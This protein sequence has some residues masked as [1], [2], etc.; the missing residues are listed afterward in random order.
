MEVKKKTKNNKKAIVLTTSILLL[1]VFGMFSLPI[2]K[3]TEIYTTT[4]EHTTTK[5]AYTSSYSPDW[6]SGYYPLWYAGMN[7]YDFHGGYSYQYAYF[8]FNLSNTPENTIKTQ[9][10]VPINIANMN[11][12]DIVILFTLSTDSWDE[13]T[14]TYNNRPNATIYAFNM[15]IFTNFL[16]SLYYIIDIT[17]LILEAGDEITVITE[18][19]RYNSSLDEHPITGYTKECGD[20]SLASSIIYTIE[21]EIILPQNNEPLF[22]IIGLSIGLIAGLVAVGVIIVLNK[23]KSK[24]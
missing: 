15:A 24:I 14:I 5:D 3:A 17:S 18:G 16:S 8:G 12:E 1:F 23:R 9:I 21:H 22:L 19:N 2:V 11:Q 7:H 10:K 4:E 20:T 13:N 6:N